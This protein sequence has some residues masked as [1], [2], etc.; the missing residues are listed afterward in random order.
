MTQLSEIKTKSKGAFRWHHSVAVSIGLYSLM[1]WLIPTVQSGVSD[2]T[3]L[4]AVLS[5]LSVVLTAVLIIPARNNQLSLPAINQ[6]TPISGTAKH[7]SK[8]PSEPSPSKVCPECASQLVHRTAKRGFNAG[9]MY[10]CC[11]NFPSCQYTKKIERQFQL[12]K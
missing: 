1:L 9:E 2:F 7:S 10:I 12:K 5:P 4:H 8:T 6:N 11:S 3:L